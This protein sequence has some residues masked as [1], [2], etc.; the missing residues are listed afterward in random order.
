MPHLNQ[1]NSADPLLGS[2]P[3][4]NDHSSSQGLSST[5]QTTIKILSCV[6]FATGA[7][8]LIAPRFTCALFKYHVPAEQA[9]PVRMLGIR[10]VVFGEL[11]VTA[12]DKDRQDRGRRQVPNEL[13]VD[14]Y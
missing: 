13:I 7:A 1:A 14:K 11:L 8:C 12:E 5:T 3:K 2:S 6:R 4:P 9:L 10:D